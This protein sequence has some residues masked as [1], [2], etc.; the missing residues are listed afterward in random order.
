VGVH[1]GGTVV[2]VVEDRGTADRIFDLVSGGFVAR[3]V[4][5]AVRAELAALAAACTTRVI[6][7]TA[8]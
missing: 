5:G 3:T 8:A 4:E 2:S 1:R 6:S 7:A